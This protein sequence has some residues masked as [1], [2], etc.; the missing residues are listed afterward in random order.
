MGF[1]VNRVAVVLAFLRTMRFPPATY[2]SA[3]IISLVRGWYSRANYQAAQ[4]HLCLTTAA[5]TTTCTCNLLEIREIGDYIYLLFSFY[6][7][8]C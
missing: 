8:L 1:E 2:H 4:M 7:S 3:N 6:T 5:T